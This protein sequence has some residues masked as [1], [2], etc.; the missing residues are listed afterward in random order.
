LAEYGGNDIFDRLY[1]ASKVEAG[2]VT[3]INF[4]HAIQIDLQSTP[5]RS[6]PR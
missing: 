2:A 3:G 5:R 6:G 1:G 4:T